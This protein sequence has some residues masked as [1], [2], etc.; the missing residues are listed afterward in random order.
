[1]KKVFRK[2]FYYHFRERSPHTDQVA[3]NDH[4]AVV[5]QDDW[6]DER[7]KDFILRVLKSVGLEPDK[8]AAVLV[9]GPDEEIAVSNWPFTH[10]VNILSFG[11]TAEFLGLNMDDR[12]H[13]WFRLKNFSILFAKRPSHYTNDVEKRALWQVLRE[14]FEV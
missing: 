12:I 5:W 10:G 1:M 14:K 13:R 6:N 4:V 11:V 8:N 7:A 2:N 3:L 9:L